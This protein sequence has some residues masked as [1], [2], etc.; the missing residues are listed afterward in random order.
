M[1]PQGRTPSFLGSA[2]FIVAAAVLVAGFFY[3]SQAPSGATGS[4]ASTVV[5]E[6]V[7]DGDTFRAVGGEK[8][9]LLGIDTPEAH[10]N[11]KLFRDAARNGQD[12]EEIK[13]MGR[14]A[15]RFVEPMILGK[16]VRLEFD[17]ERRDKYGRLLAYVYL[18]D[19]TFLNQL[20]IASGYAYPLT[21]PPNVAHA[22]EFKR[23]FKEA[24]ETQRGLWATGE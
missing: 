20:I 12:A 6:K 10:D 5:V 4:A 9:R 2:G 19:G 8:V 1:A 23:L 21:I 22:A 17:V 13:R 24:R 18:E 16:K 7:F 3:R 15:W 11:A 14:K